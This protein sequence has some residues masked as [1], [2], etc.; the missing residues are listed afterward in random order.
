MRPARM[1]A[2]VTAAA[3]GITALLAAPAGA[4]APH[5]SDR[6][7]VFVQ[8]DD[9]AGN[10]IV[11]YDRTAGGSLVR[12]GSY[13]TGGRG[14]V[15]D[16]SVVDHVAS[17][18]SLT[19]DRGSGLL[20]A[21]NA[22]SDTITS[23]AV[24]GDR[25][26]RRQ[27]LASGGSFPV[28]ITVHGN[29]VYVLNAGAGGSIQGYLRIGGVL[30]RIPAWHRG[31]GLDPAQ[32]PEF[33][34]TPGQ[35]VFTPDGSRLLVTTKGGTSSI[36]V[37]RV[38]PGGPS[39]PAVTSLPGAVPFSVAFD[40]AGHVAVAEAGPNAVAT[41]RLD[42]DG[43]LTE[44]DS[45]PTGQAATCWIVSAGGTLYLSNAGSGSLSRFAVD[46]RGSLAELG[47]TA[48]DA[49]TVDAAASADG[50]FLYVQ[51]GAAGT[52][53]AFRIGAGGS[54]TRVGSV[55]VPGAVGGEGIVAL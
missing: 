49:G 23:F 38:G 43:A 19:Y 21:V 35:V 30:V 27:V 24:H 39:A 42:R 1:L 55:T 17:Q 45:A 9:P 13:P 37:F 36:D 50:H 33:T 16:G 25:L 10:T 52:V 7:P 15:L 48:T 12:A 20:Y 47:T 28:S 54:L 29:R 51:A 40:A 8:T 46:R 3:A 44:L 41:F 34:S 11:A 22:G 6:A 2:S 53:D 26:L 32:T 14:G 18:G 31:L 4:A 5:Q